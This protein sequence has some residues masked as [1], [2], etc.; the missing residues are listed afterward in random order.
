MRAILLVISLFAALFIFG[1]WKNPK[2]FLLFAGIFSLPFRTTYSL[3]EMPD[4]Q[5][6]TAGLIISFS[7]IVMALLFIYII[8]RGIASGSASRRVLFPLAVFIGACVLS[9]LNSTWRIMTAYQA[10]MMVQ[11]VC[12]YYLAAAMALYDEKDLRAVMIFLSVVTLVQGLWGIVQFFT[13]QT[14][15]FFAT[16]QEALTET[17]MDPIAGT[18]RVMG[19]IG[20]PNAYAG[21]LGPLLIVN[22]SLLFSSMPGKRL[23]QVAI[24]AGLIGLVLSFSRGGWIAF[25]ASILFW[26][27][28]ALRQNLISYKTV[29]GI[30]AAAAVVA[31]CVAG[32]VSDRLFGDDGN[33][34]QSRIPLIK[35]AVEMIKAHPIIG[36]GI[37]TS[38]SIIHQYTKTPDLQNI[39]LQQVHNQFLLVWAEGGIIGLLAFLALLR[40]FFGETRRC[41]QQNFS[42][43]IKGIGLGIRLAF[44]CCC[45]HMMVDLY[46]GYLL[47]ATMF[48]LAAIAS[49]GAK[50]VELSEPAPVPA[51]LPLLTNR[52]P[53]AVRTRAEAGIGQD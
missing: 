38:R 3:V 34:A 21:F 12:F 27:F 9:V 33:S 47:I 52:I 8:I 25:A 18:R 49:A 37:N 45:I 42:K 16:G 20:R 24:A 51:E 53:V 23:R 10:I 6:W 36:V 1:G 28:G 35:I 39:Y 46:N 17:L 11:I 14:L 30:F 31:V 40:A 41:I 32:P 4:Y 13:N 48:L 22:I 50:I 2:R 15:D 29:A 19:T 44:L 26:T 7:D 43:D 5:G